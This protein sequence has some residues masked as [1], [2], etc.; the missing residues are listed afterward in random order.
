MEATSRS[1]QAL[2]SPSSPQPDQP[3]LR[4]STGAGRSAVRNPRATQKSVGPPTAQGSSLSVGREGS[5][6]QHALTQRWEQPCSSPGSRLA[7]STSRCFS[8]TSNKKPAT[9]RGS[10]TVREPPMRT[11]PTAQVFPALCGVTKTVAAG[12]VCSLPRR[13]AAWVTAGPQHDS[14]SAI[15]NATKRP[16]PK[17]PSLDASMNK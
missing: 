9:R 10:M 5:K 17:E 3:L 13:R 8:V 7:I 2:G 14:Q 15:K 11:N 16:K 6:T 12:Q 4:V 1:T